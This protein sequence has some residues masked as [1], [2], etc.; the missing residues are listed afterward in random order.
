[1]RY[2]GPVALLALLLASPTGTLFAQE[3]PTRPHDATRYDITIV[4]SDT[5]AYLLSEVET[6]WRLE[7]VNPVEMELDSTMH[8]I[9]VLVDGK[10]N[11]RISRTMYSRD[12]A[13]VVVP[14]EKAPGDTLTTRVRYHG[15]PAGGF[16]VG[17]DRTGARALGGTTA[18]GTARL[19]LPVPAGGAE[20]PTVTWNVQASE[21]Q[22]VVANGVLTGIDTLN[23]G[24]STWHYRL[25]VPVPLDALAV[26]ADRYAVTTLP[27]RGCARAC[28]PVTL[29]TAP[30]D[31]AAAARGAF[32]RAG[33][34][35][36]WLSGLLGP[37]P[38]PGL[39][40][41]ASVLSPAGRAGASVVLYDERRVHEGRIDEREVARATAAQWFG[42]AVSE[43]GS[44]S[45]QPSSAVAA[46]LA[47]LWTRR[48]GGKA[49]TEAPTREE[50][51]VQRLHRMVGDSAFFGGLRRY[52][53]THRNATAAPGDFERAMSEA[54]GRP[55][56]WRLG[57]AMRPSAGES[58]GPAAGQS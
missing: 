31:S 46:Y 3:G 32:R 23:Y 55:L 22:R 4:T 43:P 39:A 21:G 26:A 51:A 56:D 37:F 1:M 15:Y 13:L 9:R 5:G 2:A 12:S 14:H 19:W 57:R 11:T 33:E 34:M 29:W 50:A 54:A 42:N 6:G 8:V 47:T 10:P 38:Y 40:H 18:G 7:S 17:A 49:P 41:V 28:V 24:H 44:A 20:R 52:L 30:E 45:E 35:V 27:H 36:D 53:A 48:A 16:H 58:A 25:D